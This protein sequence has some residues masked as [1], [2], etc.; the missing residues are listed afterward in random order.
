MSYDCECDIGVYIIV[1]N[2][3]AYLCLL[4][5]IIKIRENSTF[6]GRDK[7]ESISLRSAG[8]RLSL[9]VAHEPQP[10]G[11]PRFREELFEPD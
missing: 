11:G 1:M 7:N 9:T 6:S 2:I 8:C 3:I 10:A 5:N 4:W